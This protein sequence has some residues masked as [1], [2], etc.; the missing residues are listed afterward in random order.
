MCSCFIIVFHLKSLLH[1]EA[2]LLPTCV[3]CCICPK[4][5]EFIFYFPVGTL[6]LLYYPDKEVIL[7]QY[8]NSGCPIA[9]N[10]LPSISFVLDEFA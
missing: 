6:K 3:I 7:I 4:H 8:C 2:K 1:K 10:F 9:S 5:L